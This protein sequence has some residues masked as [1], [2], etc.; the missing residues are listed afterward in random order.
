MLERGSGDERIGES[1]A[2]FANNAAGSLSDR[3]ID[4]E[5]SEWREELHRQ[6][7]CGVSGKELSAR[8]HRVVKAIPARLDRR[9]ST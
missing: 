2:E 4:S 5:L 8:D 6:V 3:S 9:R 1:E 7:R